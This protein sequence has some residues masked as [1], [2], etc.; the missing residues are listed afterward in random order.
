M[1]INVEF[2]DQIR[3][4]SPV[5]KFQKVLE[6]LSRFENDEKSQLLF[7]DNGFVFTV[8]NSQEMSLMC[9]LSWYCQRQAA[10]GSFM[11]ENI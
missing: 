11:G 8:Q 6:S 9:H 1:I 7:F 10:G 5:E 4:S 3:T 2:N